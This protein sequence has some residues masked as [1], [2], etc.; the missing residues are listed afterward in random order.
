MTSRPKSH[1]FPDG[2]PLETPGIDMDPNSVPSVDYSV[3]YYTYSTIAQTLAAGFAFLLA[4]AIY[5]ISALNK[6]MHK[7]ANIYKLFMSEL[8]AGTEFLKEDRKCD[9]WARYLHSAKHEYIQGCKKKE[10]ANPRKNAHGTPF[11][12]TGPSSRLLAQIWARHDV[13][14]G[15]KAHLKH[16]GIVTILCIGFCISI[17]PLTNARLIPAGPCA[18]TF[19]AGAVIVALYALSSYAN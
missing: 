10:A 8:T 16:S 18:F 1:E 12:I 3:Y 13:L 7:R 5:Q 15:I 4:I 9:G 11:S 17:M 19:L 6:N 2:T 14:E